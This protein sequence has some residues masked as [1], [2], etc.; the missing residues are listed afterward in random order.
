[1]PKHGIRIPRAKMRQIPADFS[2]VAPLHSL[3]EL[4]K[5]Y[6]C[7]AEA[8]K[9][10]CLES[11]VEYRRT[12]TKN[13]AEKERKKKRLEAQERMNRAECDACLNCTFKR[14]QN[15]AKCHIPVEARKMAAKVKTES[16]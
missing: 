2:D 8:V 1:M 12:P 7:G 15:A 14:C 4:R 13:G 9:R 10:W 3:N 11:G 5:K 16:A 6:K